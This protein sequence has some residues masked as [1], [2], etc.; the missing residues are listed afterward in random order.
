L[1]SRFAWK[2]GAFKAELDAFCEGAV[3]DLTKLVFS[4]DAAD[5]SVWAGA[6]GHFG[7]FFAGYSTYTDF[8]I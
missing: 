2:L 4:G 1:L 3:A 6:F 8:H 7:A 5:A